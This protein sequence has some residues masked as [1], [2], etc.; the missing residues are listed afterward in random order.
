MLSDARLVALAA[1]GATGQQIATALGVSRS[2]VTRRLANPDIRRRIEQ[3]AAGHA[4]ELAE[5]LRAHAVTAVEVLADLAA[6]P[7]TPP[8]TRARAAA[9]LIDAAVR[10]AETAEHR[11]R[12]AAIEATLDRS[13]LRHDASNAPRW[14]TPA[15]SGSL[16]ALRPYQDPDAT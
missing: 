9:A 12:L 10:Y 1:H 16:R 6:S 4:A 7:A 14:T 11:Q 5:Q 3:Y 13:G 8:A 2:T 15:A